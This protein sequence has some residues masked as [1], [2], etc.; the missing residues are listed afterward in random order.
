[1][2]KIILGNIL[3]AT[4][5]FLFL[6]IACYFGVIGR[7]IVEASGIAFILLALSVSAGMILKEK[8]D[9]K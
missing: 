4:V 8:K 7:D 2:L 3:M 9:K 6:C 1:M 5:P